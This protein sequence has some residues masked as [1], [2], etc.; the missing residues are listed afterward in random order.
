MSDFHLV[1]EQLTP[2]QLQ[3]L[4]MVSALTFPRGPSCREL[5]VA[6][7]VS[8]RGAHERLVTLS[9]KGLV[10]LAGQGRVRGLTITK[11]G[12]EALNGDS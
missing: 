9:K 11:K 10:E 1:P 7:G 5:S 4:R 3:A 6:L 12:K 8:V 2:K